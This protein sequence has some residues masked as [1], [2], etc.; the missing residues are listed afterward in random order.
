MLT[1]LFRA[2]SAA[3]DAWLIIA[4]VV[5]ASTVV[6]SLLLTSACE[7]AQAPVQP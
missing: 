2:L 4:C 6:G 7:H 5:A 1:A 3:L